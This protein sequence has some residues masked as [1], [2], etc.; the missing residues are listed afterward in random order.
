MTLTGAAVALLP[1]TEAWHYI[2]TGGEPA[3]GT[4]WE[5]AGVMSLVAYRRA[6]AQEVRLYGA[7][8]NNGA[9]DPAVTVLPDGYRPTAG[10]YGIVPVSVLDSMGTYRGGLAV[11]ADDGT[12]S[13]P[14]TTTGDTV[15]LN[16]MFPLEP[17]TA[18]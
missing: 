13:V 2:G 6:T 8:L 12:L 17:S 18:S 14:G 5:N 16:G 7:A 4:G 1:V 9:S 10:T 11:V 15:F 3:F